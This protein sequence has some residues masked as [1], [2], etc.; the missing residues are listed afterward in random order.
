MRRGISLYTEL[1]RFARSLIYRARVCTQEISDDRP[2]E[3]SERG[4]NFGDEGVE[5][6]CRGR[7]LEDVAAFGQGWGM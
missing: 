6:A 4:E 2:R 1:A 7:G 5:R 3:R